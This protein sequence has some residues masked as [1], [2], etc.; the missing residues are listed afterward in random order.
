MGTLTEMLVRAATKRAW[1]GI[2]HD[3]DAWEPADRERA[4]AEVLL[5][6]AVLGAVFGVTKTAVDRAGAVAVHRKTGMWP[7][8]G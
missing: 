6:A 8:T 1:Q 4:W 7:G 5:G 2:R 3:D